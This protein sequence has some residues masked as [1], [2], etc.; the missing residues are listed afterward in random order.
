MTLSMPRKGNSPSTHENEKIEFL[1]SK[2]MKIP[3]INEQCCLVDIIDE[4][5]KDYSS[6][7]HMTN[8]LDA[9]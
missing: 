8:E 1:L 3:S 7:P 6:E 5:V 4:C 9:F 2:F